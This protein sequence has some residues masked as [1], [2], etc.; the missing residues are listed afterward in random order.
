M[1]LERTTVGPQTEHLH[2]KEYPDHWERYEFVA[3]YVDNKKVID[4]ACGPG[5]GTALLSRASKSKVI[6]L[7]VDKETVEAASFNYGDQSDFK[8]IS[9]Y[10]WPI[11]YD[12]IDIVVS[13]ETFEH[14]D[15]HDAFLQEAKRVLKK[16]G[17]LLLS[18]PI[19]EG[20]SRF[21]PVNQFH[22]RERTR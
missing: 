3:Q 16:G 1:I 14:L 6:G 20:E 4:I 17:L 12:S 8:A 11:N 21:K 19:N 15:Q 22:L 9:G 13:L 5:Y 10:N 18:T 7:D 2:K